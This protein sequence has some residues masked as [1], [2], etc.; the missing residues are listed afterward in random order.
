MVGDQAARIAAQMARQRPA[1]IR[2]MLLVTLHISRPQGM[3]TSALLPVI[4]ATYGDATERE[5]KRELDYLHDR[6]LVE[7]KQDPL[8]EWFAKID[9]FGVDIVEFS[10]ECDPGINRPQPD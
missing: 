6:E 9:R 7:L 10:V 1:T 4:R 5:I 8:G 2:W 3:N